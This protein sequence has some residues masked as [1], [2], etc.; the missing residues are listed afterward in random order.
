MRWAVGVVLDRFRRFASSRKY[1]E[2]LQ[3][4]AT[5][6]VEEGPR[7]AELSRRANRDQQNNVH[8]LVLEYHPVWKQANLSAALHRINS[9]PLWANETACIGGAAYQTRVSWKLRFPRFVPYVHKLL[10]KDDIRLW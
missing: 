8:W 9:C 5:R 4:M 2:E 10:S 3:M 6:I 1:F 7:K